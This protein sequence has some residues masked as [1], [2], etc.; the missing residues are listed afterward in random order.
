MLEG[1]GHTITLGWDRGGTR[2]KEGVS[3]TITLGWDRGGTRMKK[4]VGHTITLGWDRGGTRMGEGVGHIAP[5]DHITR[6][7]I[8]DTQVLHNKRAPPPLIPHRVHGHEL[9]YP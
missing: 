8:F 9:R 6:P 7:F 1:V 4:G 3:H 2:M 5:P